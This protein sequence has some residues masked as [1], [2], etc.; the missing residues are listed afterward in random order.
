MGELL[1]PHTLK[2]GEY[3][4]MPYKLK[5]PQITD[6]PTNYG[7][8]IQHGVTTLPLFTTASQK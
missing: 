3:I 5:L 8:L 4:G 2:Y 7:V 1:G 6:M